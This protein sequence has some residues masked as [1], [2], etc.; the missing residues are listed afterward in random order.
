MV[1]PKPS[2]ETRADAGDGKV[3]IREI[4]P[5]DERGL[6]A[7]AGLCADFVAWCHQRFGDEAWIIEQYF[8]D[9]DWQAEMD[10]FIRDHPPP[11]GQI[12]LAELDGLPVGCVMYWP[13]DDGR[14]EMKRMYVSELARGKGA[15]R[16]LVEALI[17][18]ARSAG[19]RQ[20]LLETSQY[21]TEAQSL[22]ERTGFERIPAYH[23][24][25]PEFDHVKVYFA[26]DLTAA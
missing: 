26:M 13:F 10:R 16:R 21:Q 20:M 7:V 8:K 14:C 3:L 22:Y 4:T 9:L 17:E 18:A 23:D 11:D 24:K 5:G 1:T 2:P 25:D 6:A 12:L 15:A 19:Y